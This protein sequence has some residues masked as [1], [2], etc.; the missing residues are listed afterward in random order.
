MK[1]IEK[2]EEEIDQKNLRLKEWTEN[3]DDEMENIKD[4]Y[5]KL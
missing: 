3:D 4:P 5:N 1:T 2:K